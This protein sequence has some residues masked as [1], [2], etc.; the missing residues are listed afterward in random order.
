MDPPPGLPRCAGEEPPQSSRGGKRGQ[1]PRS[2]AAFPRS[3]CRHVWI[4]RARGPPTQPP[5][6]RAGRVE[7]LTEPPRGSRGQRPR[8]RRAGVRGPRAPQISRSTPSTKLVS[9]LQGSRGSGS[10]PLALTSSNG[11]DR[12]YSSRPRERGRGGRRRRCVS[13]RPGPAVEFGGRGVAYR[14]K[15]ACPIS[16]SCRERVGAAKAS[17]P[18]GG[19]PY[20]ARGGD[21]L[22]APL[23]ATSRSVQPTVTRARPYPRPDLATSPHGGPGAAPPESALS[24]QSLEPHGG[25][26]LTAPAAET[27]S[28]PRSRPPPVAFNPPSRARPYP[29]PWISLSP[30]RGVPG[31]APPG[32][33]RLSL[34]APLSCGRSRRVP[35]ATTQGIRVT[36]ESRYLAEQSSPPTQRYAFSYTVRIENRGRVARPSSSAGI[37]SSW[38]ATASGRRCAA[39]VWSA[40]SRCCDRASPFNTPAAAF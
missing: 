18:H 38:T 40:S 10:W 14:S 9:L 15:P 28:P 29:R 4:G 36:V 17:E 7:P 19:W 32:V 12:T 13:S 35:T 25:W 11:C 30:Q 8:V 3:F 26:P 23:P 6:L 20:C 2:Q 21:D 22:P 16:P 39:R 31:A 27:T 1:R 34:R 5:P 24:C 37:G 33:H